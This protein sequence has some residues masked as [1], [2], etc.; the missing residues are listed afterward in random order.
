[1]AQEVP[2]PG[3][4]GMD[5]TAIS[6]R[7]WKTGKVPKEI[8][9]RPEG[10]FADKQYWAP[11]C[12]EKDG[13]YYL[14]ATLGSDKD[15]IGCYALRSTKPDGPF[16]PYS[17]RLTPEGVKCLDGTVYTDP[18]GTSWLVYSRS[19]E[20]G[21][22]GYMDCIQLASDLSHSI[23][24]A[25]TL[26]DAAEAKWVVPFPYAKEEFGVDGDVYF[27]DGSRACRSWKI[28]NCI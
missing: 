22:R 3:V 16:E 4:T 18:E 8:F 10:F 23:G 7:I 11:E 9:H 27:T 2:Q 19:F 20:N 24:E 1:M 26:F 14:V 5:S 12:V 25:F 21:C 6:V 15:P 13:Y 17:K 28:A